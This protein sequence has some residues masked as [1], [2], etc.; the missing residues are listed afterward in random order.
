MLIDTTKAQKAIYAWAVRKGW[1]GPDVPHVIDCDKEG[2]PLPGAKVK[3]ARTFGDEIALV[4]S[5]LSEALEEYRDDVDVTRVWF[6]VD[7][8]AAKQF[9]DRI[10][11]STSSTN[12]EMLVIDILGRIADD[13]QIR[14]VHNGSSGIDLTEEEWDL[15]VSAGI[16][17]PM[18]IPT[19]LADAAIRL[20]DNCEHAGINLGFEIERKMRYNET[21]AFR[22]GG[23]T[24]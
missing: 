3:D 20:L 5:E 2:N 7:M 23:R 19:E 17:K 12:T 24:L 11:S 22:H 13:W 9:A 6:A 4:T 16:A 8:G 21:R 18:G 14:A 1:R 15:L 10:A